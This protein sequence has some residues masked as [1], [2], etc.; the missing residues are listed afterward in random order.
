MATTYD[1]KELASLL[2]GKVVDETTGKERGYTDEEKVEIVQ[3]FCAT[4]SISSPADLRKLAENIKTETEKVCGV[5]TTSAGGE[6]ICV[7][8]GSIGKYICSYRDNFFNRIDF[9]RIY[10]RKETLP[11]DIGGVG[12]S[13]FESFKIFMTGRRS[14]EYEKSK[15]CDG[16]GSPFLYYDKLMRLLETSKNRVK[17][18]KFSVVPESLEIANAVI[19][20]NEAITQRAYAK[21]VYK[22]CVE[23][24]T[25]IYDSLKKLE[26]DYMAI[27][28]IGKISAL[29][30]F[31]GE[32]GYVVQS[33]F[34][35]AT[36][37]ARDNSL[38]E[39]FKAEIEELRAELP[40]SKITSGA[41]DTAPE[42][43]GRERETVAS[44][45]ADTPSKIKTSLVSDTST[46]SGTDISTATSKS[47]PSHGFASGSSGAPSKTTETTETESE[48]TSRESTD[49][50]TSTT[51]SPETTSEE[52]E[53]VESVGTDTPS[54]I[55]ETEDTPVGG[56]ETTET[57]ETAGTGAGTGIDTGADTGTGTG[58]PAHGAGLGSGSHTA[59]TGTSTSGAIPTGTSYT[60]RRRGFLS[61]VG[62]AIA[63]HPFFT[64]LI[65]AGVITL[66][67][68]AITLAG[69]PF[70]LANIG[71]ILP[72]V[73]VGI[74]F[75]GGASGLVGRVVS[76][77]YRNFRYD[78]D[79]EKNF[80][81]I[82]KNTI[83]IENTINN[84]K[85]LVGEHVFDEITN[86]SD[87]STHI[88]TNRAKA[89]KIQEL[90]DDSSVDTTTI[91]IIR[92][93][94]QAK[95]REIN[96]KAK[97]NSR[98]MN[99]IVD[100]ISKK[101]VNSVDLGEPDPSAFVKTD[102]DA[103]DYERYRSSTDA[104]EVETMRHI[105]RFGSGSTGTRTG[106]GTHTSGGTGRTR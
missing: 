78:Y 77:K 92:K 37:I 45:G 55:T 25:D 23:N 99:K 10:D 5:I 46:E 100:I 94:S 87:A 60:F 81:K 98:K 52:S 53:T 43:M 51:G 12:Y 38:T 102:I 29:E 30:K 70:I 44:A 36:Y 75:V 58:T 35:Y 32:Y 39:F 82:W 72:T 27:R 20:L 67:S 66:L 84:A 33:I 104:K 65:T 16:E 40:K 48:T 83:A 2:S 74:P 13:Q 26:E 101:S 64:G 17:N 4:H 63:R 91:E 62:R 57:T 9:R 7:S 90:V 31:F 97:A 106:T 41:S 93:L 3:Q 19:S 21:K 56:T 1:V 73:F 22:N 59:G 80:K 8:S 47:G 24:G 15:F 18:M 34:D 88:E 85:S 28:S 76:P 68:T 42:T 105:S 89:Q 49:T 103:L 71:V 11:A 86:V 95:R 69:I 14:T 6:Y 79:I 61:R 96:K 54:E 50:E